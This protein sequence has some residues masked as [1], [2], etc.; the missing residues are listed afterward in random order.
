MRAYFFGNMYLSDK[1][2]GIQA[3]HVVARMAAKYCPHPDDHIKETDR[4]HVQFLEWAEE[5]ETIIIMNAGY[6]ENIHKLNDFFCDTDNPF[7]FA[8]FKESKAALDGAA[9]SIGIILP[10]RIYEA[11]K[12]V[13][14]PLPASECI[15]WSQYRTLELKNS[16]GYSTTEVY[17]GWEYELIARLNTFRLV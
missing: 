14:S 3:A 1:Q 9:T 8:M 17:T 11:A 16:T 15:P 7:P 6:G 2:H 10:Y 12:K 5:H 13:R 4:C